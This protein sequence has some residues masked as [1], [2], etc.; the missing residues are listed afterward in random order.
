MK[1]KVTGIK[2]E[3][4]LNYFSIIEKENKTVGT[5]IEWKHEV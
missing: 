5:K 4:Y 3:F 2:G 1:A